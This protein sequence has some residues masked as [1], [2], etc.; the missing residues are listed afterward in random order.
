MMKHLFKVL[1]AGL[2]ALG[3]GDYE[4][5]GSSDGYEEIET[6]TTEQ[7]VIL[8]QT[9]DSQRFVIRVDGTSGPECF[10]NASGIPSTCNTLLTAW[11]NSPAGKGLRPALIRVMLATQQ[12]RPN[13]A[14]ER[15]AHWK[16]MPCQ[17]GP[18]SVNY[19]EDGR[20][21]GVDLAVR[22]T[23]AYPGLQQ[24]T[25]A[26]GAITKT[27]S[28]NM[29]VSTHAALNDGFIAQRVAAGI[30]TD[31]AWRQWGWCRF[32]GHTVGLAASLELQANSCMAAFPTTT[33]QLQDRTR[34]TPAEEQELSQI[35]LARPTRG[36]EF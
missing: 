23:A 9:T 19:T 30:G 10:I 1:M 36:R 15:A 2:I 13:E 22:V 5:K 11:D 34:Y 4:P 3:C 31:L 25:N 32:L 27:T 21:V 33:Q 12:M 24:A 7:S 8:P 26:C 6:G 14:F 17:S 16:L 20:T 35:F 29:A 28:G 18:C